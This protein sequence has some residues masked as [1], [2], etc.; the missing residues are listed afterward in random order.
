MER[1]SESGFPVDP[2]CDASKLTDFRPDAQL[3]RPGE[4]PFTR[5]VYPRM[6]ADRRWT[7]RQDTGSATASESGRRCRELAEAAAPPV[8]EIAACRVARHIDEGDRI[9]VGINKCAADGAE[10]YRFLPAP[11]RTA[12]PLSRPHGI[13]Y[14]ARH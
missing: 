7:T 5:G 6:R 1:T 8:R 14:R 9:V 11:R 2:V 10:P 12:G 13:R 3:D 4:Y